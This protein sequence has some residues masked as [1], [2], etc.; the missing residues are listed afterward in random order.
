MARNY[1]QVAQLLAASEVPSSPAEVHGVVCGQM[2]SGPGPLRPLVS[3][4]LLG[5][6]EGGLPPVL[7]ELLVRFSREISE[8]LESGEFAFQPLLPSDDEELSQRVNAI[9]RWCEGFNV[10]FAAG[11]GRGDA[12]IPEETREVLGDFARIAEVD[13]RL[14]DAGAEEQREEDLMEVVEYVRMAATSVYLQNT[15]EEKQQGGGPDSPP[16]H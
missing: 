9:G 5:L 14:E 8:Q 6:E 13:D 10:G 12:F 3:G 4:Q 15:L 2:S 16:L 7:E 1:E 11:F